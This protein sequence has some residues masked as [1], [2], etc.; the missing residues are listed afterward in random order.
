M[1]TPEEKTKGMKHLE[2]GLGW[3][4]TYEHSEHW[5][6]FKA[7]EIIAKGNDVFQ[8][9]SPIPT[10]KDLYQL[11]NLQPTDDLSL[12]DPTVEGF[13]KWDGC[14]E[15]AIDHHVCGAQDMLQITQVLQECHKLCLLLPHC[16]VEC[17]GYR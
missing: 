15:F 4:L 13:V 5:L 2:I 11:P 10:G 7:Y 14:C 12:A 17:A 9:S 3:L 16:D 8:G 6:D 1:T